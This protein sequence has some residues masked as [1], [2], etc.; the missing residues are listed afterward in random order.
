MGRDYHFHREH[1]GCSVTLAVHL[2]GA[3]E[4]ELLVDGK[5][6][7][8]ERVHGHHAGVRSL[9]T[10]LPTDPPRRIDVEVTLPGG[11]R[12]EPA[13]VLIEDGDR[14]PMPEKEVPRRA[15]LTE[16]SWYG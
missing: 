8:V 16:A 10:V 4:V 6:V 15:G 14:L 13:G 3:R 12:G 1:A 7:A 5:E 2:G 11:V 9:S